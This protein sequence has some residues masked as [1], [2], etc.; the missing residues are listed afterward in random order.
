MPSFSRGLAELAPI[1]QRNPRDIDDYAANPFGVLVYD[2]KDEFA[3][4]SSLDALAKR[5]QDQR[6]VRIVSF[7][8]LLVDVLD[9]QIEHERSSY[10]AL[11]ELET[12]DGFTEFASKLTTI[13]DT[14]HHLDDKIAAAAEGLD[15]TRDVLFLVRAGILFPFYHV[16]PV[17]ERLGQRTRVPTVLCYPGGREGV[18]GL[19]FL[20][21]QDALRG[22]RQR[23][24]G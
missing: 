3:L 18:T 24:F 12:F 4:R 1:L 9:E 17:L 15:E 19:R 10:D 22:Y 6:S 20:N 11:Y 14:Q 8:D 5:L 23:I 13:L 2:P 7:A 21:V 16:S